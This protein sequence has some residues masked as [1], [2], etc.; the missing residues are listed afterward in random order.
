M[1]DFQFTSRKRDPQFAFD[2][3]LRILIAEDHQLSRCLLASFV[4]ELGYQPAEVADG[5]QCLEALSR[6]PF[7]LLL[8]DID[9]PR[10][11]GMECVARIRQS[12]LRI[13]I[14]AVTASV[15]NIDRS[16]HAAG[17]SGYL[18]KPINPTDIKRTLREVCLRKWVDEHNVLLKDY[19]AESS[20]K[21]AGLRKLVLAAPTGPL[22]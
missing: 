22:P 17:M 21:P 2:H 19:G 7:D 12:G 16:Y 20:L 6:R 4:R 15:P 14:I 11:D 5:I 18:N 3:P 1:N 13:P 10:M 8:I 9:M